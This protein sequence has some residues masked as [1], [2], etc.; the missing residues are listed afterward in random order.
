MGLMPIGWGTANDRSNYAYVFLN[1]QRNGLEAAYQNEKGF[2]LINYIIGLFCN[3]T[4][5]FIVVAAIYVSNYM[6]AI[7][8]ITGKFNYWLLLAVILSMGFTSYNTNTMRAGLAISFIVLGLSYYKSLCKMSCLLALSIFIHNSMIIPCG[9]IL[10]SRF[11]SRTRI[12]YYLWFISIPISF[13]AGSFFNSIFSSFSEDQR[14]G[15]LTAANDQY[16]IG[17]RFDFILYSLAPIAVGGFYIFKQK[18]KSE[19]YNN[20]YNTYIL[21]NIFWILVIRAN[22]SDRFAYLS[23]FLIPFI[24]LYPILEKS[25]IVKNPNKWVATI[26]LGETLFKLI[27]L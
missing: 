21:T 2:A 5:Y 4:E 15:Y 27:Q 25:D 20:I 1:I 17:F 24:L 23:W 26:V 18:F 9:M 3:V 7:K 13:I 6:A 19:F 10:L 22:F 14:T 12:F 8:R 16:N 11:Y